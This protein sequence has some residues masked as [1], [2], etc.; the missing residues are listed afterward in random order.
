MNTYF[1]KALQNGCEV[2]GYYQ[3]VTGVEAMNKFC[4]DFRNSYCIKVYKEK[5][6]NLIYLFGSGL[7]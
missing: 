7:F 6:S 3:S 2:G 4:Q 5:G 1:V